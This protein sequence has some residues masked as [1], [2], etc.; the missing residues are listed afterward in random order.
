MKSLKELIDEF[1]S[2]KNLSGYTPTY[3]ELFESI[4]N[5]NINLLEIGIGTIISGAQSSMANTQIQNYKPGASLRVWKTYF[6]NSLVY[7]G[8]IQEDTQFTEERIQTF[9]FDST[10]KEQCDTIL[11][12]MQF[13]VI[14]DDGWHRWDAQMNTITNLFNRVKVG[15][16]YIIEDI[17]NGGASALFNSE[18]DN[19]QK[20]VNPYSI[21]AN[22]AKNLIVIHKT[23]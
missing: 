23:H 2:D 3:V 9:L 19:L 22:D 5:E 15:G 16:F 4:R 17:E 18:F 8:D 21:R 7:G 12:D 13:D 11:K 6:P 20:I 1:G 14:I 10:N